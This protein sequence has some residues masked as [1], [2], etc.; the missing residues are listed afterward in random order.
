MVARC[1]HGSPTVIAVAPSLEDGSPF[2]T[3]FWLVCPHLVERI[4]ALESAGRHADLGHAVS[5][6]P[7]LAVRMVEADK[8]YRRTRL[9]EGSGQDACASVGVAGQSDPLV[10]KCL[11]ARVAAA[12]AG[13]PDPVGEIILSEI[14][15]AEGSIHC[16]DDRCGSDVTPG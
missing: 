14:G 5:V 8:E 2:P 6:D 3:T 7:A 13:I 4:H 12:L 15:L 1:V 11:H 16:C 9:E 10:V